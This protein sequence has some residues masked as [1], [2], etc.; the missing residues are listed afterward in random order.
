VQLDKHNKCTIR[1]ILLK[2]TPRKSRLRVQPDKY[3]KCT[4]R[5]VLLKDNSMQNSPKGVAGQAQQ[6]NDTKS[7]TKRQLRTKFA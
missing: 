5:S 2:T 4:I 7:F 3:N 6:V 1:S